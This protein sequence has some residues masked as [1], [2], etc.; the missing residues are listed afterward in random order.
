[1]ARVMIFMFDFVCT[2]YVSHQDSKESQLSLI[3]RCGF[4]LLNWQERIFLLHFVDSGPYS[5]ECSALLSSWLETLLAALKSCPYAPLPSELGPPCWLSG[6]LMSCFPSWT[7][8]RSSESGSRNTAARVW[9]VIQH[10]SLGS[11]QPWV[12]D[13]TCTRYPWR[14]WVV[15]DAKPICIW[16]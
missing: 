8:C 11:L 6:L 2:F 16:L 7:V 3:M 13:M 4:L 10:R 1:M 15:K 5:L 12:G 14:G 9:R